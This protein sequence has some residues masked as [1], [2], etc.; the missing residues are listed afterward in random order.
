MSLYGLVLG[1]VLA[2]LSSPGIREL[3]TS[4]GEYGSPAPRRG[5][6]GS[7]VAVVRGDLWAE[8]A[9]TYA[10]LEWPDSA[11]I[12]ILHRYR[13]AANVLPLIREPVIPATTRLPASSMSGRSLQPEVA[14]GRSKWGKSWSARRSEHTIGPPPPAVLGCV[15]V[16]H[17]DRG[18]ERRSLPALRPPPV[19]LQLR[20]RPSWMR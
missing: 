11:Q 20:W 9:F 12:R 19:M 16:L 14:G 8:A 4:P 17:S 15:R 18:S 5:F 7:R 10:N 3:P 6:L 13:V 1:A 2:E